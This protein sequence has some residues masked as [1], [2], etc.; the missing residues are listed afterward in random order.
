MILTFPQQIQYFHVILVEFKSRTFLLFVV[1]DKI[2]LVKIDRKDVIA[3]AT[4]IQ[5]LSVKMV[6]YS[7]RYKQHRLAIFVSFQ[8]TT[9]EYT[10]TCK[11]R[12]QMQNQNANRKWT[13]VLVLSLI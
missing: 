1:D 11:V 12:I 3:V 5:I 6:S 10:E 4:F 2:W 8:N 13:F 7:S 9:S